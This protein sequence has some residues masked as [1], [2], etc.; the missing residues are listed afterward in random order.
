M[1]RKKEFLKIVKLAQRSLKEEKFLGYTDVIFASKVNPSNPPLKIDKSKSDKLLK[2]EKEVSGCKKCTL[3]KSRIKTVFGEGSSDAKVIFIGEGP[4][5][6]EDRAGRPF[7]GRAGQLL[8]KIIESIGLKREE[9]FIANIVKCHPMINPDTPDAR[10]NDR[11]PSKEE[12]ESCMP[13][14]EK[15]IEIINP[16]VLVTLG[17]SS[18]S[19]LLNTFEGISRLRGKFQNYKGSKLLPMYHPSAL[20]RNPALKVDTWHDM[21]MLKKELGLK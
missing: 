21:K 11:P 9:V 12:M 3:C 10:G 13:Y 2:L 19:A 4:G 14:L 15:Q 8:T 1:D 6:D 16:A 18:T 7:I 5:Y 17:N 20:L